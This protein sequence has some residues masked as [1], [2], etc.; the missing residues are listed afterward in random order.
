MKRQK[1]LSRV[2]SILLTL[3]LVVSL[4]PTQALALGSYGEP[5][6]QV[7]FKVMRMDGVR[8]VKPISKYLYGTKENQF[9]R[10]TDLNYSGSWV[11][12]T[13]VIEKSQQVSL[14]LYKLEGTPPAG[15]T[16]LLN[17]TPDP[18]MEFA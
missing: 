4:L 7:A 18:N 11:Q 2:V 5:P 8:T 12:L 10:S 1:R 14:E 17:Y 16:M 6:D 13:Y 3:A 9:F 15:G